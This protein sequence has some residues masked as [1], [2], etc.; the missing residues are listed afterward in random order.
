MK[1]ILTKRAIKTNSSKLSF[2]I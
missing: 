1:L 2:R